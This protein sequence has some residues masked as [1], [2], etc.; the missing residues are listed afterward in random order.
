MTRFFALFNFIEN[1]MKPS[2]RVQL[3]L[4]WIFKTRSYKNCQEDIVAQKSN[5]RL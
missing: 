1:G 5:I 2:A 4:G 3:A